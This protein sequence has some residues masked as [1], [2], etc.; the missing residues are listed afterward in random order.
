MYKTLMILIIVLLTGCGSGSGEPAETETG[1]LGTI[2]RQGVATYGYGTHIL[3][4]DAGRTIYALKS[5]TI[6]M[7]NYLDR[8]ITVDGDLI[9]G[10]PVDSGPEYLN[11]KSIG[12]PFQT[13][14][15][16][17]AGISFD[18]PQT[19]PQTVRI[20]SQAGWD[21]FWIRINSHIQPVPE[22][23][24][25][26]FSKYNVVAAVDIVHSNGGFGLAIKQVLDQGDRLDLRV[27]RTQAGLHCMVTQTFIK[28]FHIIQVEK[29]LLPLQ[30]VLTT[31]IYNCPN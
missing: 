30:M 25:V 15:N 16:G 6:N 23:P 21:D 12:L 10:Y 5:D 27:T 22:Q 7:D 1:T 11:V 29:N 31:R 9:D 19:S 18:S 2:K 17:L 13:I 20:E 14:Q 3:S 26:D 4:D 24:A 8:K 28:P